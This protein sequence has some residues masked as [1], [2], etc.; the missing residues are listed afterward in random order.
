VVRFIVIA[1]QCLLCESKGSTNGLGVL[2]V[3]T[4]HHQVFIDVVHG[5]DNGTD[6]GCVA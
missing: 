2:D 5:W 4:S 6:V 1:V 3:L